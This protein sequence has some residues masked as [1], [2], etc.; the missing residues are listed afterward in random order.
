MLTQLPLDL[1]AFD[2][3]N[4]FAPIAD[5]PAIGLAV[6]G[7]AD[8]LA[9]MLL[10]QRWSMA[11]AQ[12]P[13]IFVYTLDHGL[14]PAAADEVVLVEKYASELGLEARAL[15]WEGRK[16]SSGLQAAARQVRYRL[17]GDAMQADGAK[18]LLTAH[19]Q[20]DQAETVLMR[21]A[22]GSGLTGLGGMQPETVVEN[23]AVYRPLLD[24]GKHQLQAMVA[25]AGWQVVADPSNEDEHYERVRWRKMAPQLEQMGL[26]ATTLAGLAK[27]LRRADRALDGFAKQ[28]FSNVGRVDPFGV[29]RLDIAGFN[30]LQ[31][32]IQVRL[33]QKALLMAGDQQK[34]FALGRFEK[35]ADSLGGRAFAPVTL[36]GCKVSKHHGAMVFAR[37][38]GRFSHQN[39]ELLPGQTIAWDGRF[40]IT[41][42]GRDAIHVL[43]A[44]KFSKKVLAT[45]LGQSNF[46]MADIGGSPVVFRSQTQVCA[47]GTHVIDNAITV[48]FLR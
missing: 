22:H 11:R 38:G 46:R 21:L 42:K 20:D 13:K 44:A 19:H 5:Y 4:M 7:G 24:I 29:V 30:Q 14:R 26:N 1:S 23:I 32:E 40:R 25:A 45:A 10:A 36:F 31:E 37:E 28:A 8:S 34:P 39:I 33:A 3:E 16:P 18:V 9:L 12:P 2:L 17:I 47:V 41:N 43:P 35:F 6:S 27:R 15:K 48:Q